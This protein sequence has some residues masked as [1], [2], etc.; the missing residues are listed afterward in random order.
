MDSH[1][2]PYLAYRAYRAYV[3][4]VASVKHQTT[5]LSATITCFLPPSPANHSWPLQISLFQEP[6]VCM[7]L[8]YRVQRPGTQEGYSSL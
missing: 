1:G 7:A 8:L 3:A 4:Y 2:F 6:Y 5:L